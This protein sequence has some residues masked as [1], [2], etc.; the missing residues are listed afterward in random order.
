MIGDRLLR[1]AHHA[2]VLIVVLAA[3][4]ALSAQT[5]VDPRYVEFTPSADHNTLASDGTPIVQRYSLSLFATGSS[6]AFAR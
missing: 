4:I 2:L 5:V 6:V 1:V 3:T